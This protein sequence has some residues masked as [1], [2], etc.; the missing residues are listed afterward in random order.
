[1]VAAIASPERGKNVG[2]EM[3]ARQQPPDRRGSPGP[4]V[5]L[6][7]RDFGLDQVVVQLSNLEDIGRTARPICHVSDEVTWCCNEELEESLPRVDL[8]PVGRL[9]K[10]SEE[11]RGPDRVVRKQSPDVEQVARA[12]L[13]AGRVSARDSLHRDKRCRARDGKQDRSTT[14][15]WIGLDGR[16]D[17]SLDRP[18]RRV[19]LGLPEH[20]DPAARWVVACYQDVD[21]YPVPED[22]ERIA[23]L[24]QLHVGHDL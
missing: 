21:R 10:L 23:V 1:M 2:A 19:R 14:S 13:A 22:D 4:D 8:K 24:G 9:V 7:L 12:L 3:T 16:R 20:P 5:S 6:L 18:A 17:R 11:L 15:W